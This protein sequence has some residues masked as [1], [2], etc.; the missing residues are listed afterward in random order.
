MDH[1]LIANF[2]T[3][4]AEED[5]YPTGVYRKRHGYSDI[6]EISLLDKFYERL[7]YPVGYFDVSRNINRCLGKLKDF[8]KPFA[9]L[10]IAPF[11]YYELLDAFYLKKRER[12]RERDELRAYGPDE[13][14]FAAEVPFRS[15]G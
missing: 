3:V 13:K 9:T 1:Y 8:P 5:R 2:S 7:G 11:P 15:S 10:K 12:E 14:I 4:P 6:R